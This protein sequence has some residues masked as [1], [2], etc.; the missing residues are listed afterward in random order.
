[1]PWLQ[2]QLALIQVDGVE[3]RDAVATRGALLL[4]G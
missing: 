1:M 2:M 4:S 3:G